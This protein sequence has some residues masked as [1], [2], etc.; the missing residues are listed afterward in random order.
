M[1]RIGFMDANAA[2][3]EAAVVAG[4]GFYAGYP[5][6][7]SSE[8]PERLSKIMPERGV[9]FMMMEDEIAS[10]N[11]CVGAAASGVKAMTCT[12]GP[13]LSLK[14]EAFGMACMFEVPLVVVDVMRGGPS[15][16]LPTRPSQG[17]IM[18]ARWGTHGDHPVIAIAPANA[19]EAVFE[20]I[21]AFNLAE[22]FRQPVYILTDGSLSHLHTKV[23]IPDPEEVEI[24]DRQ[25]PD[26]EPDEYYPYDYNY[27]IPPLAPW[28]TKD[29]KSYRY[30]MSS[31]IHDKTGFPTVVPKY[32]QW[33]LNRMHSKITNHLD[34]I[35]KYE[36][37]KMDDAETCIIAFGS[38]AEAARVAID[39]ARKE[40][41]KV[42]MFRP[43]TVWPSPE[44]QIKDIAGKVKNII[45]PEMNLGQYIL[46]VQ[47]IVG[48]AANVYGISQATGTLIRPSQIL[49]K[50][51]NPEKKVE[52]VMT[53]EEIRRFGGGE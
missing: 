15:T 13:G 46:E 3:A 17:D 41:I 40:G 12:S 11:A 1:G 18:Q 45:V 43:L 8:V 34:E 22:K 27:E 9:P 24:V 47:R 26:V 37:Y 52:I 49:E 39:E 36:Y 21:R 16:G 35:L 19:Q 20:T 53:D 4:L 5:I 42:G 33:L 2:I 38:T 30:H 51:K 29:G 31:L 28:W 25:A 6:T 23:Y 10:I 48:D 7:P 50:I 32:V 44:Q 14:Q